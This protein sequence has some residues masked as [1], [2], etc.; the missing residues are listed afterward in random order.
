MVS[1]PHFPAG[2][3]GVRNFLICFPTISFSRFTLSPAFF[4]SSVVSSPVWGMT[5]TWK[6][7]HLLLPLSDWFRQYRLNLFY[8]QFQ[9]LRRCPFFTHTAFS[10]FL[11]SSIIPVP[12]ICPCNDNVHR[13]CHLPPSRVPDS[14]SHR[15][16]VSPRLVLLTLFPPSHL[17]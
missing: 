6:L 1:P 3:D 11:G 17:R 5:D 12:S 7:F 4:F 9:N 16:F 14:L 8:D 15:I 10:S 13:I 2:S